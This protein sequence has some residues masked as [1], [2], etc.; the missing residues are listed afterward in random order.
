M[1]R[2]PPLFFILKKGLQSLFLMPSLISICKPFLSVFINCPDPTPGSFV[3]LVNRVG[4]CL[5]FFNLWYSRQ[6]VAFKFVRCFFHMCCFMMTEL[7]L[8]S[9]TISL[10]PISGLPGALLL[11]TSANYTPLLEHFLK[12]AGP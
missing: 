11:C 4:I 9:G 2:L 5:R 3:G 7:V 10:C 1:E 12:E 6:C 8:K